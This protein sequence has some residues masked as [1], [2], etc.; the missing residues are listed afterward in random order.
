MRGAWANVPAMRAFLG[1]SVLLVVAACPK[2]TATGPV[3]TPPPTAGVGCPSAQG[4]HVAS[5]VRPP[6]GEQ[7]HTGW[8]LPLHDVTVDSVEGQ[9][10]FGPVDPATATAAGVPTPPRRVWLLPP[11]APMCEATVG[12]Y[13]AAAIEGPPPNLAYGVELTGCAAPGDTSDAVAIALVSEQ[14][15]S[16]C[17]AIPPR[18]V[19]ARL[20]E[21]DA[22]GQW[23]RPTKETPIPDD[24][25]KV[26]PARTCTPPDCEPLWSVARVD[27]GDR[28]VAWAGAVNWLEIPPGAAPASQCEWKAETFSGFFVAG[29]D[30]APVQVTEGQD[31]PLVLTA[32]LAD[33]GGP[34]V[35]L[36]SGLGEYSA[37]DLG[38]GAATLGR[39]LVWLV[40]PAD[41]YPPLDRL[42]PD[43]PP[44]E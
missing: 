39:H 28:P 42:G 40:A 35:L 22:Q 1:L 41:A 3:A 21:I 11:G 2:K 6:E 14:P 10:A 12:A 43:C 25:A 16:Q 24:F 20:G 33:A 29:P 5:F 9:P 18:P 27:V 4:V 31:H 7:G 13:Y 44:A 8:V 38:S 32:V 26:V 23:S 37:Y 15:P 30:G 17:K 34:R 19:A 36:A